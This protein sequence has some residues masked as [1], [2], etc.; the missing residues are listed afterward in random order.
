MIIEVRD[1]ENNLR[2]RRRITSLPVAVGRSF[3]NDIIIDD[4]YVC[5]EHLRVEPLDGHLGLL[6][7][8]SSVNGSYLLPEDERVSSLPIRGEMSVRIGET[9]ISFI[10]EEQGVAPTVLQRNP[11][12]RSKA[13]LSERASFALFAFACY[14]LIATAVAYSTS[15]AHSTLSFGKVLLSV[16]MYS[17]IGISVWCCIWAVITRFATHRFFFWA[18]LSR[19]TGVMAIGLPMQFFSEWFTFDSNGGVASSWVGQSVM[20]VW[21]ATLIYFQLRL[22]SRRSRRALLFRA[23]ILPAI[24]LLTYVGFEYEASG[25]FSTKLPLIEETKPPSL[26]LHGSESIDSFIA[27][28]NDLRSRLQE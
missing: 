26:R 21:F 5:P 1:T 23:I 15:R 22:F 20:F 2:E 28:S 10:D 12:K 19:A 17:V 18:H 8:V 27:K 16:G 25:T 7:D 3:A 9:V 24:V 14:V 4:C 11:G 13:R 6:K